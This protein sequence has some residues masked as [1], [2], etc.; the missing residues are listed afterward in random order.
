MKDTP[1]ISGVRYV[2]GNRRKRQIKVTTVLK[3]LAIRPSSCKTDIKLGA[4][5]SQWAFR[6]MKRGIRFASALPA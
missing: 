3:P 4:Y 2:S 1:L 5:F 6:D